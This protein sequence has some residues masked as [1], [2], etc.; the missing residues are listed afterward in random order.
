MIPPRAQFKNTLTPEV[1]LKAY[2]CGIFPMAEAADDPQLF[3]IQPDHRGIIPLDA[4]HLPRRL[5]RTIRTTHLTVATDQDFDAIIDRCASSRD[6]TW[7]NDQIRALYAALFEEGYCHTV[8]VR[9]GDKLVGGLYGVALKGVFFGE[10]MFSETRDASKIAMVH[11]CARLIS[12]GFRLLD[13]QFITE[14]LRQFGAIEVDKTTF[15]IHL[16]R[17]LSVYA[18][19]QQLPEDIAPTTVI[20][21][22]TQN[23][24]PPS[25]QTHV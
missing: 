11:L 7:I 6:S 15:H 22:I 23:T 8:E 12:G 1:L 19:F 25:R 5:A 14:H 17:A 16:K 24:P 3:W 20:D 13:T 4:V 9:D 2:A 10:S 18:N 21:I